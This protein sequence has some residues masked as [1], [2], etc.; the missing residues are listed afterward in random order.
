MARI[1]IG[2][3]QAW[4]LCQLPHRDRLALIADG[5]PIILESARGFWSASLQL[6]DRPREAEVLSG[7]A[8][9]EAAKVLILLDMVRCPP[10]L[11]PSKAGAIIGWFYDHLAR[12]IYAKAASW[13]PM[14]VT[15]L[16]EYV[17]S[18]RKAHY[19]EGYVGEY[20]VPNWS[21]SSR[22]RLLYADIEACED[23]VPAWNKP[24]GYDS[25]LPTFI[26]SVLRISEALSAVGVFSMPGVIATAEIFGQLEFRDSQGPSDA[27]RLTEEL[28]KRL[29]AENLPTK[30]ATNNTFSELYRAWQ[31]PMYNLDFN[32]INVPLA[33]LE[34]E[35]DALLAAEAGY[36]PQDF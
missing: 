19:L 13:K 5:L 21:L 10:S 22:E 17:N 25:G 7:F 1:N 8:R 29:I 31:L 34:E 12:L 35:R 32:V 28:L 33:E 11:V 6:K 4:R 20:I 36:D 3:R 18:E 14:H 16:Q 27:E 24:I 23:E 15:Q 9:E 26:P 30:D 2:L